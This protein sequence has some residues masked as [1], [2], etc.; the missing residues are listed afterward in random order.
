MLQGEAVDLLSH[1]L[2]RSLTASW[3]GIV[4]VTAQ[5]DIEINGSQTTT[6]SEPRFWYSNF[7]LA[8][9]TLIGLS[10]TEI[11]FKVFALELGGLAVETEIRRRYRTRPSHYHLLLGRSSISCIRDWTLNRKHDGL[12]TPGSSCDR[13]G[14]VFARWQVR[15]VQHLCMKLRRPWAHAQTITPISAQAAIS[16]PYFEPRS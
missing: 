15:T 6:L 2:P 4:S 10:A 9:C 3:T 11:P 1:H 14:I 8:R 12:M 16:T 13:L 7:R 5:P